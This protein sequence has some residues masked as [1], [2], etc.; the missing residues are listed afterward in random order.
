LARTYYKYSAHWFRLEHPELKILSYGYSS[1][2]HEKSPKEINAHDIAELL[3]DEDTPSNIH[4]FVT[5]YHYDGK[6]KEKRTLWD[7]LKKSRT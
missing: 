5:Q 4:V 2:E 6:F 7:R 3:K 1:I